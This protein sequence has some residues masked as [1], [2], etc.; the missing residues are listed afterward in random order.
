METEANRI[1]VIP[2]VHGRSFWKKA[3][4]ETPC[5]KIVFLGDYMDP[6]ARE[7]IRDEEALGVFF[8]VL[9]VKKMQEKKVVLLLGNHDLHYLS[10]HFRDLA[11]GTRYNDDLSDIISGEFRKH[12]DWFCLAH[13]EKMGEM[14]YLFTHAGVNSSW[15]ER[16]HSL[17]QE[18][19]ARNLNRLLAIWNGVIALADVGKERGGRSTT[20]SMV[21]ADSDEMKTSEPF[22]G[23]YQIFG[24]S[25]HAS[26]IITNHY[27]C[28]DCKKAFL[29]NA[30]GL[31]MV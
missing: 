14:R 22:P 20:G 26:P 7:G 27:A 3:V 18:L 21:W 24:H 1:L 25:Q 29:L 23:V 19:N 11:C 5:E 9:N 16:H 28:L 13:E 2:D 17:I 10:K 31:T 15:Y 8:D 12:Q 30:Q 6:Y 4:E